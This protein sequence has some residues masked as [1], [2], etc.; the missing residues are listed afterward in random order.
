MNLG[1]GEFAFLGWHLID[2][3]IVDHCHNGIFTPS[4][5]PDVVCQVGSAYRLIA[6]AINAVA[7]SAGAKF[8]LSEG[9]L[10]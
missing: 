4:V 3:A 2:L 10:H 7:C 5:Q 1:F 6:F 8:T 9:R